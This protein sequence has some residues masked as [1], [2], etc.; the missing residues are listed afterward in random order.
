MRPLILIGILIVSVFAAEAKLIMKPYLQAITDSSVIVLAETD[1]PAAPKAVCG[2][3]TFAALSHKKTTHGTYVHRIKI[4]G[5]ASGTKQS[6]R[7][8]HERDSSRQAVFTTTGNMPYTF[9]V[10]GDCRSFTKPHAKVATKIL[11]KAPVFSLYTGDLCNDTKYES[12]KKE[13]FIDEQLELAAR[14]PFFNAV[15]NHEDISDNTEAFSEPSGNGGHYYYSFDAGNTHFIVLSTESG[16]GPGSA[17]Y[18]FAKKDLAESDA[19]FKV[20]VFHIP[21]Y[22]A[23][24]HGE[25]KV[26]K[27]FTEEILEPGG[28]DIV[29]NGHSHFYQRNYVNGIYHIVC[30]GA[31]APL[32]TPKKA[33][34]TQ[35]SVKSHHYLMCEVSAGK[36]TISVYDLNDK[37]I[38]NF[39]I[40]K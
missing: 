9:A 23:G 30:A 1:S 17:Q 4:D 36:L 33:T 20:A 38:D 32:Y 28:I 14:V 34:Y 19:E 35:K 18:K 25:N 39:E 6:Y 27:K 12:W 24:G 22:S 8:I 11:A 13:F 37:L 26:M 29:F 21:A 5:L 15:G 40:T 16:L 10:M 2:N 7:I 3:K 31:G